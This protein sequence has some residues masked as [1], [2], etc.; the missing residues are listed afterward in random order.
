[1][2]RR[3]ESDLCFCLLKC[4]FDT[5][6]S[7]TAVIEPNKNDLPTQYIDNIR[8]DAPIE[9]FSDRTT[10]SFSLGLKANGSSDLDSYFN[11]IPNSDLYLPNRKVFDATTDANLKITMSTTDADLTPTFELDRSRFIFIENLINST[12]NTEVTSRPETLASDGGATSKY[13]T[14]KVTL[15][16]DFDADSLRVIIA[17]N[18]PA[19]SSVKVFYRVQSDIDNSDFESLP[20]IE[21]TKVTEDVV[22]Q[23]ITEYYDCEYKAD[24]ITYTAEESS[25]EEFRYFQIKLVLFATNT[26][27]APTVK[28][29]RAIALSWIQ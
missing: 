4:D 14:K 20:F 9:T 2:D 6:G 13:I 12:S 5:S 22:N 19:G 10:A 24:N 15:K 27:K 23:N 16:E 25:F 1:L 26:A 8:V 18:L 7:F 11:M 3:Q 28:N 17:K 21:M 29:L